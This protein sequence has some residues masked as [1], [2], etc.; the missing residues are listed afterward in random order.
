MKNVDMKKIVWRP[1]VQQMRSYPHTVSS[2]SQ[3]TQALHDFNTR[4]EWAGY[5]SIISEP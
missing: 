4:G 5:A 2:I 1:I 3:R